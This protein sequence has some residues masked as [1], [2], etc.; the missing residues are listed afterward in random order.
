MP[1]ETHA[2]PHPVTPGTE[3]AFGLTFAAVFLLLSGL[4]WWRESGYAPYGLA[5]SGAFLILGLLAP[6]LLKPF[7]LLWFRFGLLLHAV[8]SPVILGILF[9]F[10]ITPVGWL[11]RLFGK[12]PLKLDYDKSLQSYWIRRDPP[13]PAPDSLKNQF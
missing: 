6:Q 9:Y 2:Q 3:R 7:N 11:M 1:H 10:T 5:L 4:G 8:T 13:G 12:R